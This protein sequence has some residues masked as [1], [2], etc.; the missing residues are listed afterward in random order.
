MA[1]KRNRKNK[2][3]SKSHKPKTVKRKNPQKNYGK[4]NTTISSKSSI[5]IS[6]REDSGQ[7]ALSSSDIESMLIQWISA[8]SS[9]L[10]ASRLLLPDLLFSSAESLNELGYSYGFQIGRKTSMIFKGNN[11]N[12]LVNLLEASGLGRVLYLPSPDR[13]VIRSSKLEK[14]AC[15]TGINMHAYEAGLISGYLSY[16][17]TREIHTYETS[18]IY[19]GSDRCQF[20]SE[21]SKEK[22]GKK[23]HIPA[24]W[25]IGF[26]S[27]YIKLPAHNKITGGEAE[28]TLL[29]VLPFID[30]STTESSSRLMFSAGRELAS[31]K[32]EYTEIIERLASLFCISGVKIRK[33]GEKTDIILNYGLENSAAG[34]I[35]FSTKAFIGFLSKRFNSLITLNKRRT[36]EGYE[37][38]ISFEGV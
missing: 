36:K 24:K 31:S 5:S 14:V 27:E 9:P 7:K 15:N 10:P 35:E 8:R 34:F 32:N 33:R 37:V 38:T 17:L 4:D 26:L 6:Q 16:N 25:N 18:C 12:A 3:A 29:G 2:N 19:N 22:E 20:I 11:I 23:Q 28:Y 1:Y 21:S 13:A 30:E